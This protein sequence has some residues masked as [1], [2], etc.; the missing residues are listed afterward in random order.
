[1]QFASLMEH[2]NGLMRLNVVNDV[3]KLTV[4]TQFNKRCKDEVRSRQT[5][6]IF[7]IFFGQRRLI[8]LALGWLGI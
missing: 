6:I 4:R 7:L 3:V 5:S 1:M 8:R 2:K